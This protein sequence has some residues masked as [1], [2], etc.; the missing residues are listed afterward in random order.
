M[1]S[2]ILFPISCFVSGYICLYLYLAI[3][4]SIQQTY[5]LSSENLRTLNRSKFSIKNVIAFLDVSVCLGYF[6]ITIIIDYCGHACE[7]I[8][9]RSKDKYWY[10]WEFLTQ[11][12]NPFSPVIS[13]LFSPLLPCCFI[14]PLRQVVLIPVNQL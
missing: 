3:F 2:I 6:P 8:L 13:V 11:F 10:I 4:L 1:I 7:T 9:W 5:S 12:I 14:S